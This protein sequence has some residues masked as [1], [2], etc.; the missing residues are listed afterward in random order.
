M[1]PFAARSDGGRKLMAQTV[2]HQ[3]QGLSRSIDYRP[4]NQT[5]SQGSA[6]RMGWVPPELGKSWIL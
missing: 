3:C 4:A 6:E 2:K 5:H 1:E